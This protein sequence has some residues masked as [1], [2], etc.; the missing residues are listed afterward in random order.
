MV[1]RHIKQYG[2]QICV[3]VQNV[4]FCSF[5]QTVNDGTSPGSFYGIVEQEIFP[6]YCIGAGDIFSDLFTY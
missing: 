1:V 3:D 5:Y 6:P 2:L 4:K